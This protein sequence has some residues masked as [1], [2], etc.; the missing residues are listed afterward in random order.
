MNLLKNNRQKIGAV[1]TVLFLFL[2]T[3]S[4]LYAVSR[5]NMNRTRVLQNK[6]L[7]IQR[8]K[9]LVQKLAGL[10]L[11]TTTLPS[12]TS[13]AYLTLALTDNGEK[14]LLVQKNPGWA[15]PIASVTKLMTAIVALEDLNPDTVITATRDYIGLEESAFILETDRKYTVRTLLANMLVSSDNDSARLLSSALGTI[16]FVDKMNSK[17]KELNLTKTN[18]FNVTG[19]DPQKPDLNANLSSPDDLT[20]LLLYIRSKHPEILKMTAEPSAQICDVTGFCKTVTS[21]DKLLEN[22]DFNYKIIGGKTGNTDLAGHNLALLTEIYPGISL[23]NIVLGAEDNFAD[24]LTLINNV[25]IE[26]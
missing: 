24:T 8:E 21:T 10:R 11:A 26:N 1:L 22:K 7:Q 23:I 19:L 18:F 25:I 14:R 2:F 17:A 16:N 12:L 4:L 15:L 6:V 13:R 20:A 5:I 3:G 9:E